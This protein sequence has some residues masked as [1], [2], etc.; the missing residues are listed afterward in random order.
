MD[1]SC[2]LFAAAA[3]L[4]CLLWRWWWERARWFVRGR[5]CVNVKA[6]DAQRVIY[7]AGATATTTE[8]VKKREQQQKKKKSR[9]VDEGSGWLV[10]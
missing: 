2:W 8:R 3:V 5:V 1:A 4:A 6:D 9:G 10:G 7:E